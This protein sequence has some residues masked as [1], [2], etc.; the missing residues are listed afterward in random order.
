MLDI[1][2]LDKANHDVLK[3]LVMEFR[4]HQVSRF[5]IEVMVNDGGW[6][7][8]FVDSRFPTD[9]W[10]ATNMVAMLYMKIDDE[11][12]TLTIESRLIC[13]DKYAAYNDEYHTRS[14]KD[15]KKMLKFMKDYIKPWSAHE[16]ANKTKRTMENKIDEWK[17]KPDKNVRGFRYQVSDSEIFESFQKLKDMG[18]APVDTLMEKLYESILPDYIE[19]KERSK[20]KLSDLCHVFFNPDGSLSITRV[21]ID[22]GR[23][24]AKTYESIEETPQVVQNNIAML[25]IV[26]ADQFVPEVGYKANNTAYWIEGYPLEPNA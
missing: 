2:N 7:I 26:E 5:P 6:N 19:G 4:K 20:K 17:S 15:P 9:R 18:V 3:D 24:V 25:K 21:G 10:N 23:T 22:A 11:K 16:I 8:G 1:K 12:P 13:N 14:T